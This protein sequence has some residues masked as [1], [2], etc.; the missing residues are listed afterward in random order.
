MDD[1]LTESER[2]QMQRLAALQKVAGGILKK[3]LWLLLLVFA[4]TTLVFSAILVW[5]AA[6]SAHR[7]DAV[8]RLLYNPRRVHNIDSMSDKQLLTVLERK[9]LKRRVSSKISMP[10]AD[11]E[12][13]TIDLDI[14]Q[15]RK[16][17][18][19][20][21]LKAHASSWVGAVK[22]VN[23]YAEVLIEEYT[24]YRSQDLESWRDSLNLRKKSLQ[25]Q[26]AALESEETIAKGEAG[27]P[28]PV[29]TLTMLNALISD[30][31]RNLSML[32][33]QIVN[34]EVKRKK[35]ETAVGH[36]GD[37]VIANA[38]LIRKKSEEIAE[39]DKEISRLRSVY[40]DINPKVMGRLDDRRDLLE[41]YAALL[42][43]RGLEGVSV[44]DVEKAE[45]NAS[46]L[47]DVHMRL[48]VLYERQRSL[49][50][51]IASNEKRSTQLTGIIPTLE[52][53]RVKRE[54]LERTLR[55]IDEQLDT[56]AY[57]M[58]S[59]GN[60]LR[61]IERAG[62]AG[63]KRPLGAKQF[64]FAAGG[65][66][67]CTMVL[68]FWLLLFEFVWGRVLDAKEL[69]AYDDVQVLGSLPRPG[70]LSDSEE[71]DVL[72]VLALH[73]CNCELPKGIVLVCRLPGS[74]RRQKFWQA[75]EWS[76]SMSGQRSFH[77]EIVPSLGFE[78]PADAEQGSMINTVRRGELGWFT[79]A[80]RYSF[81][82]TELQ[83]LQAD[84]ATLRAEYDTIF[85]F[86][87]GGLRRGGS[88]FSQ[89]LGVCES[90]LVV[91]A[92]RITPRAWLAYTRRH[93]SKAGKPMMGIV[94]GVS[95]G[96]VRKEMEKQG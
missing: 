82:P 49:T 51:E 58:T 5:R 75:L 19:L 13:L 87:P 81:A 64:I 80:N 68:A 83:M 6:K 63:D 1:E 17:T 54:D 8:T 32:S 70:L 7:F 53:L 24:A 61:Q 33:V 48:E 21:T 52:R 43:E 76:M 79:V 91:V 90:T 18:N 15:E 89:L 72:G 74:A 62:G 60:D 36:I 41:E 37:A 65:G 69:G 77:L 66:F 20:F 95:A 88:F 92:A 40:T 31:R 29:E 78:P 38:A 94:T 57:L 9:S 86:M 59:I 47:A 3:W 27:V 26:I 56:I 96:V 55:D 85:I 46:E 34:E 23:A 73:F 45:Q 84:I 4:A 93:I 12:C 28:A 2:E 42:K 71:D 30:Q 44:D 67:I 22:K 10:Q 50:Q 25:S 11:R 14:K 39:I 16:P 35:L